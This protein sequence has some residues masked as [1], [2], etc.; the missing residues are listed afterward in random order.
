MLL[1]KVPRGRAGDGHFLPDALQPLGPGCHHLLS[2]LFWGR[3]R[4]KADLGGEHLKP[5]EVQGAVLQPQRTGSID[6]KPHPHTASRR[7]IKGGEGMKSNFKNT[8]ENLECSWVTENSQV[9]YNL[10]MLLPGSWRILGNKKFQ[11][12]S[13]ILATDSDMNFIVL[14]DLAN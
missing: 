2:F 6:W 8:A 9:P 13:L 3:L 10:R 12:L 1:P 14:I 4:S 5:T 7:I 11:I